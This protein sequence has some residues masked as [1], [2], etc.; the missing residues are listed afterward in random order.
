MS[1]PIIEKKRFWKFR[2]DELFDLYSHQLLEFCEEIDKPKPLADKVIKVVD[3]PFYHGRPD[4][5]HIWN[6]YHGD[7]KFCVRRDLD[8]WQKGGETA[9]IGVGDCEDSSLL[10]TSGCGSPEL[11][12]RADR[13]YEVFGVVRDAETDRILGGHAWSYCKWGGD[14]HYVES[15]LDK[16]PEKYPAVED[17]RK[18]YVHKKWKLVPYVLFNWK[19]YEELR[20]SMMSKYLKMEFREKETRMKYEAIREMWELPV[21]PLEKANWLSRLR[22]RK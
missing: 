8:F 19:R 7:Q 22:W 18:P 11:G 5:T 15:T 1:F 12:V 10:F 20:E 13:V 9:R 21:T 6:C 17:I 2:L 3:Y 14:W 4:N 16:P